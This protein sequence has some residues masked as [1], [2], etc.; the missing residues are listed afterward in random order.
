VTPTAEYRTEPRGDSYD[1]VV[2][3]SGFGGLVSAAFLAK[4]GKKVLLAERL[5][6]PG[7]YAH[8]F[9][10]GQYLIDPAVHAIGQGRTGYLLDT[11]LSALGVR[12]RCELVALDPFYT[13][14][15]P[16]DYRFTAPFG[17]Q[18]FIDAHLEEFPRE[19]DGFRKF[20]DVCQRIKEEWDEMMRVG[21]LVELGKASGEFE[22]VLQHRTST[23]GAVMDEYLTD[24]RL[25][26]VCSAI[27]GY[28]GVPPSK[29]SFIAYSG[30]T[31]SLLEGGQN[32]CKGSFQNV[33]NA[34]VAALEANGGELVVKNEVNRILVDHGRVAG[35]ELAEGQRVSA[36]IVVSNADAMQTIE[37]MVG[38]DHFPSKYIDGL[39]KMKI[40]ISAFVV[41]TATTLDL[42]QFDL[43]H[44]IFM[45]NNW[46]YDE[47]WD[48]VLRGSYT[49]AA[50]TAPTLVD[51]SLAPPG[52]HTL[53]AVTFMPFDV[54]KPWTEV[55]EEYTEMILADIDR[56]FPGFREGL[57]FAESATPLALHKY[58][59]NQSGAMYGW[60]N[61]PFQTHS[62]RPRNQTPL[63][64]L[65]LAGAWAQPGSGTINA[66]QSGFQ[67]AQ[68]ILGFRD[69]DDFLR[70]LGYEPAAAAPAGG[71]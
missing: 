28:Q 54:G 62:R 24:P 44:E 50:L 56:V 8:S 70:S 26:A 13:V 32:Y 64:G 48:D 55:K 38:V 10:R 30:M 67:T 17:V 16:G 34:Y 37:G 69:K 61:N 14:L 33:V 47:L 2:V 53:A 41:Y 43:A 22:T 23:L 25:K 51:P 57:T 5:D 15:L 29:L 52:E 4:A 36:P 58:S 49:G 1:A 71:S 6:G 12:D 66:M 59:L 40:S 39:R 19:R 7:G 9:Q 18:E 31:V 3:G 11:W 63:E 27:W 42:H 46:D 21:S 45:Y 68:I 35:V 20:M 60:E 65:Y